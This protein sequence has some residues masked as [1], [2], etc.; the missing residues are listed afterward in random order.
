[1]VVQVARSDQ[2]LGDCVRINCRKAGSRFLAEIEQLTAFYRP[3][4]GI[5]GEVIGV[6]RSLCLGDCGGEGTKLGTVSVLQT[7]SIV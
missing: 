7:A 3:R 1:V 4:S 6:L 5:L 2:A